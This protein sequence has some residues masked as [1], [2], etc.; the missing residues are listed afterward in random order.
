MRV[1]LYFLGGG[2]SPGRNGFS[3]I[4]RMNRMDMDYGT[5]RLN[6]NRGPFQVY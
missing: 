3:A 4:P 2:V 1:P 6:L 5:N